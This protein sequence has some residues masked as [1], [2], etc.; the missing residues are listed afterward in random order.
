MRVSVIGVG[1]WQFG[2]ASG[3]TATTTPTA[4]GGAIVQRALDLGVNLID[5]AEIYGFGASERIVGRAIAGPARRGVRRHQAVPGPAGRP[6]R[7][8]AAARAAPRR[9][10][11]D[12]IDLYQV[13]W[14]NPV[15][16]LGRRWTGMRRLLER[17]LVRHV[18]VSNFSLAPVA[19]AERALGGPVLSN[20][21]QYSLVAAQARARAASRRAANDR[22]VIAYSPL[23][24]GLLVGR[25]DGDQPPGASAPSNPLFLPDNLARA[26]RAARHAARRRRRP[27]RAR[28]RRSRWRG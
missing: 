28:P 1:T 6:G 11:V 19:G 15:V 25:Y 22:L 12:A 16:P 13:H 10:G 3:A 20:Q 14:P 9:L 26:P 17:G 4:T 18:G 24:Q 23:G 5:T 7:G 27:R 2:S 21:V 8:R